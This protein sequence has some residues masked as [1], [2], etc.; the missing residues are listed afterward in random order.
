MRFLSNMESSILIQNLMLF[1]QNTN[2]KTKSQI[3]REREP[4]KRNYQTFHLHETH[5]S[6]YND[7][8]CRGVLAMLKDY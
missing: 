7:T 3:E 5:Y 4:E 1:P 6:F 8:C 2:S